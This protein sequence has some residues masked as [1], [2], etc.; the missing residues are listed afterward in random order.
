MCPTST[1]ESACS[2]RRVLKLTLKITEE[3]T[4]FAKNNKTATDTVITGKRNNTAKG[5]NW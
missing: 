3:I 5:V 1:P 4:A 2:Y